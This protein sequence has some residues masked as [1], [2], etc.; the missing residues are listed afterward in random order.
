LQTAN[1]QDA[2]AQAF[3][4]ANEAKPGFGEALLNLG[5][6]LRALGQEEKAKECWREAVGLMPD[7]AGGYFAERN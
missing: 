5:H 2:A 4:R 6:A 3:E 7:L 1:R